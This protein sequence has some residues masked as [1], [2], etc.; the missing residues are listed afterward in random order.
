MLD[1]TKEQTAEFGFV[2]A[3]TNESE[4]F[5]AQE[6]KTSV[7]ENRVSGILSSGLEDVSLLNRE[8]NAK[9][10][11]MSAIQRIEWSFEQLPNHFALASSFGVQSAV[12]LHMMTQLKPDI[13][14]VL[15]DTNYLFPETYQFIEQLTETLNLNLKVFRSEIGKAWQEARYGKLWEG[16]IEGLNRYNQLNKVE[17]M[18][19][20]LEQLN[21]QTWFSGVM[22]SQ[23]KSRANLPVVQR[24]RG[25]Y[26]VHPLIDWNS[27]M[28]HQYLA[29]NK[30][31]YHPLW[32]KGYVSIGDVHST[33]PLEEGMIEEDT[34]FSGITRECGLHEDTLSGL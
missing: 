17:P 22:R 34:R 15:I 23:S 6:T 9:L 4:P 28:A 30:L 26:K 25:R 32:D 13:P 5:N 16:G 11:S 2:S 27:R 20:G 7:H 1:N 24:S 12:S 19:K 8:L 29:K 18:E 3:S 33:V 14:V 10:E 21:I 31:P